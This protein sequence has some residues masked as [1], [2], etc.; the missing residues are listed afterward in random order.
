ML[1]ASGVRRQDDWFTNRGLETDMLQDAALAK[2][3]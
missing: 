2:Q 3:S 1:I